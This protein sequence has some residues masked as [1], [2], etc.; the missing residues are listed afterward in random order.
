M[1]PVSPS[2]RYGGSQSATIVIK[3]KF[4]VEKYGMGCY[5]PCYA[6]ALDIPRHTF[7]YKKI[8]QW[9]EKVWWSGVCFVL[10]L[11]F[12]F[13]FVLQEFWTNQGKGQNNLARAFS[14]RKLSVRKKLNTTSLYSLSLL[15]FLQWI[16]YRNSSVLAWINYTS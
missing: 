6:L 14:G 12:L 4:T 10:F 7:L 3:Y 9:S 13:L 11:Y 16:A 15:Y 1:F 8:M 2:H 5:N